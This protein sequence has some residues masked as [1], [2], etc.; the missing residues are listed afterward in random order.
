MEEGYDPLYAPLN[1]PLSQQQYAPEDFPPDNFE[2]RILEEHLPAAD[3]G[4]G[5][6]EDMQLEGQGGNIL[7]EQ[8]AREDIDP[9]YAPLNELGPQVQYNPE[10]FPPDRFEEDLANRL[11]EEGLPAEAVDENMLPVSEVGLGNELPLQDEAILDQVSPDSFNS[12]QP[13]FD[14][15]EPDYQS[16]A[17]P[18][19]SSANPLQLPK[20]AHRRAPESQHLGV[21]DLGVGEQEVDSRGMGAY[22]AGPLEEPDRL[23]YDPGEADYLASSEGAASTHGL[24]SGLWRDTVDASGGEMGVYLCEVCGARF[25]YRRGVAGAYENCSLIMDESESSG[26]GGGG[27]RA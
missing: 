5:M 3:V 21:M 11:Y 13:E 2:A 22:Y 12:L 4:V 9:L 24:S 20:G 10:D 25:G 17:S 16:V 27:S 19:A 14:P 1:D 8:I 26:G 6:M 18:V 23:Y 15:L 7:K